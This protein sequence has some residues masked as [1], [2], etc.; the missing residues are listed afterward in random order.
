MKRSRKEKSKK[1]EYK[2]ETM[3]NS[4]A[5][6]SIGIYS[7][8]HIRIQTLPTRRKEKKYTL[9]SMRVVKYANIL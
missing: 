3:L 4:F 1:S 6:N 7:A 9:N 8:Q 5:A 2:H